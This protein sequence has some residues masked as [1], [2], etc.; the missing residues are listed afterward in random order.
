MERRRDGE[1]TVAAV[2]GQDGS[3]SVSCCEASRTMVVN[4]KDSS[5]DSGIE[6]LEEKQE[7]EQER[8]EEKELRRKLEREMLMTSCSFYYGSMTN[9]EAKAKLKRCEVCVI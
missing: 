4:E 8:G 7:E 5:N 3:M 9:A 6:R 1:K 2:A